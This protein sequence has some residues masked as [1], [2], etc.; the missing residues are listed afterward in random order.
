MKKFKDLIP[1]DFIYMIVVPGIILRESDFPTIE[2]LKIVRVF[3]KSVYYLPKDSSIE[4]NLFFGKDGDKDCIC[5]TG[6]FYGFFSNLNAVNK[7]YLSVCEEFLSECFKS[8]EEIEKKLIKHLEI[9]MTLTEYID[10]IKNNK[11]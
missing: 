10:N 7:K 3:D 1:G 4:V 11:L 8:V 9:C 2:K 5:D 6:Y